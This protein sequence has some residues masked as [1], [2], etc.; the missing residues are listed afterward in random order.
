MW[1]RALKLPMYSVAAAPL[2]T[3]AAMT[4][5][6]FGCVNVSQLGCFLSGACLVIAWLNLANDAWDHSTGVDANE[7]GHGGKPESVVRLQ[8]ND[9]AAV[10]KTHVAATSALLGRVSPE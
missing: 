8:G 6:W 5:H 1:W 9:D 7:N 2:T 10:R 3:A 4:H